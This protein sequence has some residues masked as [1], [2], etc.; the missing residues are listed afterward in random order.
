MIRIRR[1]SKYERPTRTE[2]ASV[3]NVGPEPLK[4]M[5]EKT[6]SE[7]FAAAKDALKTKG[8]GGAGEAW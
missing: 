4:V 3:L 5:D 2:G 6:A 8:R 1:K 7:Y